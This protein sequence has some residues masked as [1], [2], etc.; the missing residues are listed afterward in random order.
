MA[1]HKRKS[2]GNKAVGEAPQNTTII[3]TQKKKSQSKNIQ[4]HVA[5]CAD[6]N[7]VTASYFGGLD[8]CDTTPM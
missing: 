4:K 2:S 8:I 3:S 7:D 6:V 1:K 5:K